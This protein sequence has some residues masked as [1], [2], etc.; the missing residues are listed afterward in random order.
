MSLRFKLLLIALSTL[1]LPLF[2]GDSMRRLVASMAFE[3]VPSLA[4]TEKLT[5]PP[6]ATA[7]TSSAA[8]GVTVSIT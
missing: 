3:I 5:E 4:S 1:A 2:G 6:F 8:L 7:A